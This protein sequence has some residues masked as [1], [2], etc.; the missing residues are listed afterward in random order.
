MAYLI[1]SDWVID[2]LENVPAATQFLRRL[3]PQGIA[4]SVVTYME[5]MQ[6]VLRNPDPQAARAKFDAFQAAV[7]VL[8]FSPAAAERCAQL[9]EAL[10]QQNRRVNSRALDLINAAIALEHGLTLVTR[11]LPDYKDIPGLTLY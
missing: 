2:H 6:G 3:A 10:K 1:D 11:N 8:P 7:P 4:I 5:V 9:R